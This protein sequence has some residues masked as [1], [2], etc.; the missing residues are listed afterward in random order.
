MRWPCIAIVF[1]CCMG[2][3]ATSSAV[4]PMPVN[5]MLFQQAGPSDGT[6]MP[7]AVAVGQ[8]D[9]SNRDLIFVTPEKYGQILAKVQTDSVTPSQNLPANQFGQVTVLE[10]GKPDKDYIIPLAYEVEIL[11]DNLYHRPTSPN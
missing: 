3:P 10:V 5:R 1:C 8:P 9:N 11:N 4:G 2:F 7:F 6:L